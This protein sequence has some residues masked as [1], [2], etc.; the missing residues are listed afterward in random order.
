MY[1]AYKLNKQ[2]DKIQ[3]WFTPFPIWNHMEWTYYLQI[4]EY[5]DLSDQLQGQP[6]FNYFIENFNFVFLEI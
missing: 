4:C 2:G 6:I 1:S 5:D 3:P